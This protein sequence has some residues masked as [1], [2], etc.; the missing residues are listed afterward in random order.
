MREDGKRDEGWKGCEDDLGGCPCGGME[1][2]VSKAHISSPWPPA[3]PEQP[4]PPLG[5]WGRGWGAPHPWRAPRGRRIQNNRDEGWERHR[6]ALG[7]APL[8]GAVLWAERSLFLPPAA[9]DTRALPEVTR[10]ALAAHKGTQSLPAGRNSCTSSSALSFGLEESLL[11]ADVSLWFPRLGVIAIP[12]L[13]GLQLLALAGMAECGCCG[14]PTAVMEQRWH[15]GQT[16]VA[17]TGEEAW[18]STAW[19]AFCSRN[20]SSLDEQV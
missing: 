15:P 20:V 17:N 12:S 14:I 9:R 8:A 19:F 10:A 18:N 11:P 5:S 7:A 4:P 16:Q 1:E 6:S 3:T 13:P 2:E